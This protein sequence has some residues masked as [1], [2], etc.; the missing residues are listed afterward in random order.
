MER[1]T[2]DCDVNIDEGGGHLFE[3]AIPLPKVLNH[4]VLRGI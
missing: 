2:K 4:L 1:G 3:V